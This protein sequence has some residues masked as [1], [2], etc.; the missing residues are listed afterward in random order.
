M[1]IPPILQYLLIKVKRAGL[2]LAIIIKIIKIG[3]AVI[4]I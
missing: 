1:E 2:K 4:K 3:I